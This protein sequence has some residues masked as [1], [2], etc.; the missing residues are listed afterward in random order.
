MAWHPKLMVANVTNSVVSQCSH[1]LPGT[2]EAAMTD[3]LEEACAMLVECIDLRKKWLF[4][5]TSRLFLSFHLILISLCI[6]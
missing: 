4:R 2:Q 3:E 5:V 6:Q 1:L